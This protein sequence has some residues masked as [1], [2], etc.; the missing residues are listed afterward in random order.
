M[1]IIERAAKALEALDV[2]IPQEKRMNDYDEMA[3]AVLVA[4]REPNEKMVVQ[5]SN[6]TSCEYEAAT[7]CWKAMIDEALYIPQ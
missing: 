3:R 1:D 4:I 7:D 5:G 6:Y 2:S